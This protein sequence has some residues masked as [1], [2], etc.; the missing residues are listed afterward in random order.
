MCVFSYFVLPICIFHI[1]QRVLHDDQYTNVL[2][3]LKCKSDS[4]QFDV[5]LSL[6]IYIYKVATE[7]TFTCLHLPMKRFFLSCSIFHRNFRSRIDVLLNDTRFNILG[8]N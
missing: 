7:N 6:S 2:I 1:I 5:P 8:P 4:V 3:D